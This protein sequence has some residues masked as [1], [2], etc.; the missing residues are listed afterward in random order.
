MVELFSFIRL[1]EGETVQQVYRSH[2]LRLLLPLCGVAIVLLLPWFFLFDYRGWQWLLALLWWMVGLAALWY[3]FDVW[4]TSVVIETS[5]RWIAARRERWGKVRV[6]EWT[7][8]RVSG[9][10]WHKTRWG[11][12]G[13]WVW[14]TASDEVSPDTVIRL[15][16]IWHPSAEA[17]PQ[18][19][20]LKERRKALLRKV[21]SVQAL[22]QI[23]SLERVFDESVSS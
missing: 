12:F 23:E 21:A 22:D 18:G 13:A 5:E 6:S 11:R 10:V 8:D 3:V 19:P 15:S 1:H 4:S 7:R 9:P 17:V 2:V 14:T 20:S 16:W